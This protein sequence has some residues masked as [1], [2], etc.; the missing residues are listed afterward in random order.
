[1]NYVV[2]RFVDSPFSINNCAI[3]Y[4]LCRSND[5]IGQELRFLVDGKCHK[6][7]YGNGDRMV[8]P[9]VY[10]DDETPPTIPI[11]NLQKREVTEVNTEVLVL[12]RD[13]RDV[14]CNYLP[15]QQPAES[16]FALAMYDD[17]YWLFD[18][19]VALQQNSVDD[20]LKDGGGSLV[21]QT[22]TNPK[23]NQLWCRYVCNAIRFLYSHSNLTLHICHKRHKQQP[24]HEFCQRAWV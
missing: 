6:I 23:Q 9:P 4:Q 19:Q 10:F 18:P 2:L 22:Q 15:P 13:V 17:K 24:W 11:V 14:T 8:N 20:P 3:R 1:M 21:F 16:I 12:K 7:E 5:Q